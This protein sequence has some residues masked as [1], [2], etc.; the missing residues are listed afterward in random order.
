MN[1]DLINEVKA[2]ASE[3][4]ANETKED[5]LRTQLAQICI[6]NYNQYIYPMLVQQREVLDAISDALQH[7]LNLYTFSKRVAIDDKTY[8]ICVRFP[9]TNSNKLSF[10]IEPSSSSSTIVECLDKPKEV[11]SFWYE[12][13]STISCFLGNEDAIQMTSGVINAIFIDQYNKIKRTCTEKNEKLKAVLDELTFRLS[14]A[15]VPVPKE[16]GTVEVM[17][18]GKKFVGKLEEDTDGADDN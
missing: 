14:T 10:R 4:H 18:G 17:I 2:L 5:L 7:S 12:N 15:H 11:K 6:D 1:E 16:D 13:V 3:V 9:F 8:D